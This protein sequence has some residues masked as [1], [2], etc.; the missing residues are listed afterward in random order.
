MV[1][2]T[3]NIRISI[4]GPND[5]LQKLDRTGGAVGTLT[6]L[7][8]FQRNTLQSRDWRQLRKDI[9]RLD[10]AD[11]SG[12]AAWLNNAGYVTEE[13]RPWTYADITNEMVQWICDN[14]AV[15]NWLMGLSCDAYRF[16]LVEA[17]ART[18][19]LASVAEEMN[20]PPNINLDVLERCIAVVDPTTIQA[21]HLSLGTDKVLAIRILAADPMFAIAVSIDIDRKFTAR[22]GSI[23][24]NC[25]KR[26]EQRS[27]RDLFCSPKCVS[28]WHVSQ[29]R[30]KVK[31]LLKAEAAWELL[32]PIEKKGKDKW[33]WI[34]HHAS[35]SLHLA[36][37]IEPAWAERELIKL[38]RK[39][40]ARPQV[41]I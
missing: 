32:P 20:A 16:L 35:V 19:D 38:E 39:S 8:D 11:L 4:D 6:E 23:C 27:K 30:G 21:S 10:P 5:F 29:R 26:F 41:P 3:T 40:S 34:A 14:A 17:N 25:G 2:I 12:V 18:P 22:R 28:Q 7:T 37:Q 13:S 15:I 24:K 33:A 9:V 1:T 31:A 36:P